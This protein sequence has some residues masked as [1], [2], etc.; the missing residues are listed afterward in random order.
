M[1]R[2]TVIG[3]SSSPPKAVGRHI[4]HSLAGIASATVSGSRRSRS[5]SMVFAF[6]SGWSSR[7]TSTGDENVFLVA[8]WLHGWY[9]LN[10][11]SPTGCLDVIWMQVR[12]C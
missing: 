7:M 11:L 3:S 2:N 10:E 4:R 9:L 1:I 12:R 5:A 6:R 8:Q